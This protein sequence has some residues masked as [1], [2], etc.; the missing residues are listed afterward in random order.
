MDEHTREDCEGDCLECEVYAW[1]K[2]NTPI[3]VHADA[4]GELVDW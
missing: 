2:N 1:C 4:P 3:E